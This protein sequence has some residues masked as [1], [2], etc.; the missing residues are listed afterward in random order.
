MF[1]K[2]VGTSEGLGARFALEGARAGVRA[3]VP[4]EL[5]T[6]CKGPRAPGPRARVGFLARVPA[7]VCL[8]VRGLCVDLPTVKPRTCVWRPFSSPPFLCCLLGRGGP[9]LALVM[10]GP[11]FAVVV[12]VLAGVA[13]QCSTEVL[14]EVHHVERGLGQAFFKLRTM[15]EPSLQVSLRVWCGVADGGSSSSVGGSGR[16]EGAF[17]ERMGLVGYVRGVCPRSGVLAL[18]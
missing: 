13:H 1:V 18:A 4:T 16:L 6:A 15:F 2:V 10:A 3:V 14:L 11:A 12:W 8:E 5:V 7:D 9:T 17:V